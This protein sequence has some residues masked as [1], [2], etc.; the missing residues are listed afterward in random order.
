MSSEDPRFQELPYELILR[1]YPSQKK[2]EFWK[3]S[4]DAEQ[5]DAL[6][7]IERKR[8]VGF[9]PYLA[10][11]ITSDSLEVREAVGRTIVKLLKTDLPACLA[12][13]SLGLGRMVHFE[14]PAPDALRGITRDEVR[15]LKP[16]ADSA[17]GVFGLLS[18][19]SNGWVREAAL[20][21]LALLHDGREIPFLLYRANDWV[22]LI[23]E[24]AAAR[25]EE[26]LSRAPVQHFSTHLAVVYQQRARQRGVVS[27]VHA[28]LLARVSSEV[29]VSFLENLAREAK[30]L[31]FRRWLLALA[32][33]DQSRPEARALAAKLRQDSDPVLRGNAWADVWNNPSNTAELLE[34]L[35]DDWPPIRRRCLEVLG[36]SNPEKHRGALEAALFDVSAMMRA[37]GR[38]FLTKVPGA[39][40]DKLYQE[41]LG[42]A[43]PVSPAILFGISESGRK[44]DVSLLCPFLSA[45]RIA[46]RKAAVFAVGNLDVDACSSEIKAALHDPSRGVSK[47]ALL[48]LEKHPRLLTRD[49]LFDALDE[50][51]PLHVRRAAIRLIANLAKWDR[52]VLLLEALA[53]APE[54]NDIIRDEV[55]RWFQTYN[56]SYAQPT[57][58]QLEALKRLTEAQAALLPIE[59]VRE[60]RQISG[61]GKN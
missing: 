46:L 57:R 60:L 5:V 12:F 29:E 51:R 39:D 52:I 13:L 26:R 25:F 47:A 28:R 24:K 41:R 18:F 2:W 10:P 27:G 23:A 35:K 19:H 34:G 9:L 44:E 36:E 59:I 11:F 58:E 49:F 53:N 50:K 20:D 1:L 21:Q 17:W 30:S 42:S 15:N 4:P 54:F 32:T 14:T 37:T 61:Q 38:H 16:S 40:P 6:A 7:E 22:S 45:P 55:R 8:L 56:Q 3:L 48:V 33:A 31:G 43:N